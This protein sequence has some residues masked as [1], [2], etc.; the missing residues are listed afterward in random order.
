M[1]IWAWFEQI[2]SLWH[3]DGMKA[4]RLCRELPRLIIHEMKDVAAT[5]SQ[6]LYRDEV[7]LPPAG[8][9]CLEPLTSPSFG[10]DVII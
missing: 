5:D 2:Q 9:Q 8:T 3:T 10:H 6:T 7:Q 4:H 1:D